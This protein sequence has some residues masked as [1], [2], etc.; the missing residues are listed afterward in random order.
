[1]RYYLKPTADGLGAYLRRLDSATASLPV[2]AVELTEAQTQA[3]APNHVYTRYV[4]A[5]EDGTLSY[6]IRDPEELHRVAY[7][8]WRDGAWH[9]DLTVQIFVPAGATILTDA[10][11]DELR[12]ARYIL[13]DVETGPR[14]ATEAE[15]DV[16]DA[17]RQEAEDATV[18]MTDFRRVRQQVVFD[19]WGA[20]IIAPMLTMQYAA[21]LANVARIAEMNATVL[22]WPQ[23]HADEP[24]EG[25]R[26][27]R[28]FDAEL[29]GLLGRAGYWNQ[30]EII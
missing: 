12:T 20:R 19:Y 7:A 1:M 4:V 22:A 25:I 5:L 13:G 21:A 30:D 28:R 14:P 27:L 24:A 23:E 11:Y 16:L 9:L 8:A 2:G 18:T 15:A 10:R 29:Q 3:L 17:A 26:T 6:R